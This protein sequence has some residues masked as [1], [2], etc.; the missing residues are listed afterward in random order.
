MINRPMRRE[1]MAASFQ[2]CALKSQRLEWIQRKIQKGSTILFFHF[3]TMNL[4]YDFISVKM[5][6][7]NSASTRLI[8]IV[9][10]RSSIRGERLRLWRVL[11]LSRSR[12]SRYELLADKRRIFHRQFGILSKK[13]AIRQIIERADVAEKVSLRTDLHQLGL[14]AF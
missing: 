12:I 2:N 14:R 10:A 4:F 9:T 5:L 8:W 7:F 3:W 13:E 11:K 1:H 6:K